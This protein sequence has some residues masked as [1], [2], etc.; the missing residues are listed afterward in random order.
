[1][2][3]LQI[4]KL[5]KEGKNDIEKISIILKSFSC[6]QEE[7]FVQGFY[8]KVLPKQ[9]TEN[10]LRKTIRTLHKEKK[11][12]KKIDQNFFFSFFFFYVISN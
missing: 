8:H 9:R 11:N 7:N 2:E 6:K 4:H 1:M 3:N 12:K 10:R 5:K